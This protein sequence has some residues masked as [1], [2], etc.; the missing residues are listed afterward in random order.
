MGKIDV[1]RALKDSWPALYFCWRIV[2]YF[3]CEGSVDSNIAGD[4]KMGA[5]EERE[6]VNRWD[7]FG[8]YSA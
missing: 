2:D 5:F 1:D 8:G 3:D 4:K 6:G 7:G